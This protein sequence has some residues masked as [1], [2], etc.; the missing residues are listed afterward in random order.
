MIAMELF[1]FTSAGTNCQLLTS[2]GELFG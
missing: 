1:Q 2:L